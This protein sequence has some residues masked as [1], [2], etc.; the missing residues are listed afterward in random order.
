MRLGAGTEAARAAMSRKQRQALEHARDRG[1]EFREDADA[2]DEAYALHLAQSGRWARHLPMPLEL[3]RRLLVAPPDACGPVARLFTL[4]SR[5][6]LISA[7]LVL[8]GPHETFAWWSGTHAQGRRTQAFAL[9]LWS[10]I[11]WAAARGRRRFNLGASAGLA[12]V[13]SF[14]RSLGA[15]AFEFPVSWLDARHAVWPGRA[16]AALQSLARRGRAT[17]GA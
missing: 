11:E 4:R 13:S 15:E 7:T 14:K 9:L 1:Y 16:V 17:G 3:S 10:A 12:A 6:G 2:L 8:D 5:D